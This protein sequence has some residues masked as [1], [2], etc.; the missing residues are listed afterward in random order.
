MLALLQFMQLIL[1]L[2]CGLLFWGELIGKALVITT[3]LIIAGI[4]YRA[5]K[6]KGE[7]NG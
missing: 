2:F 1:S 6:M 3:V 5:G 7:N 4:I